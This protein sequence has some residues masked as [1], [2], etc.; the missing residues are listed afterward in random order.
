MATRQLAQITITDL[1]D[2]TSVDLSSY[3]ISVSGG[4]NGLPS[5][6][7]F[8]VY[9]TAT[10]GGTKLSGVSATTSCSPNTITAVPGTFDSTNNRL[11]VAITLPQGLSGNGTITFTVTVTTNSDTLTYTKDVAVTVA[12]QGVPGPAGINSATVYLYQRANTTPSKPTGNITY[13]FATGE[14]SGSLGSWQNTIPSGS[15]PCYVI[16]ATASSNSATDTIGSGEWSAVTQLVANGTNGTNG[17]NGL[18]QATVYLYK[19]ASSAPSKP[20]TSTTYTFSTGA[21]STLPNSW[22]RDIPA[23][24]G[25]PCW[26]T[27]AAAISSS[28]TYTFTSSSWSDVHKLVEDGANGDDAISMSITTNN[29]TVFKNAAAT[30][31]TTLTAHVFVGGNE[32]TGSA[33]S[34]L[35]TIKWYLAGGTTPLSTIANKLVVN[36]ATLQV[37]AS[38]VDNATCFEARLE[39]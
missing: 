31:S 39:A 21:L 23:A 14:V 19:R 10:Q 1:T 38:Y 12:A 7:S 29:G 17:T 13:T 9:I 28:A 5:A 32:V 30:T 16:V 18:N 37:F 3:S 26:V 24:D 35:G 33:L 15:N 22:V 36:G 8:T 34:N 6:V 4:A 27:S 2:G 11:P 25:N 20:S